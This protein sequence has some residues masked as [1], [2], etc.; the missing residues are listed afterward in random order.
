MIKSKV[1]DLLLILSLIFKNFQST[2]FL[3]TFSHASVML[4]ISGV[5]SATHRSNAGHEQKFCVCAICAILV[6]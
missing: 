1:Q 4:Y 3:L 5:Q 2:L 6:Q